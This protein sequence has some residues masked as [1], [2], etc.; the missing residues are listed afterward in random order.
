MAKAKLKPKHEKKGGFRL[1]AGVTTWLVV[2]VVG[3]AVGYL[4][5][6]SLSR[7]PASRAPIPFLSTVNQD[8]VS[9]TRMLGDVA[10]DSDFRAVVPE[11][12]ARFGVVDSLIA[13]RKFPDALRRLQAF[14]RN[15]EPGLTGPLNA[16]LGLVWHYS[17]SPDRSLAAFRLVADSSTG[18]LAGWAAFAAGWLFQGRGYQDSAVAWY[19]RALALLDSVSPVRPMA[20]N[21]L[22]VA[23][24]TLKDVEQAR[25]H[26]LAAAAVID[27]ADTSRPARTLR[28]NLRRLPPAP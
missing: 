8:L 28:D 11:D 22:G 7:P 1:P 9:I 23:W 2:G 12:T 4:L 26:L 25:A 3:V 14:A 5:I 17:S 18:A 6:S 27:T 21:N 20:E 13:E 16:Y 10:F 24:E 15:P 19:E